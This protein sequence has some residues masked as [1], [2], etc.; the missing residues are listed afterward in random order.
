MGGLRKPPF[1]DHK[2]V[3]RLVGRY[4]HRVA[5]S[6]NRWSTL[7]NDRVSFMEGLSR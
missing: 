3:V 6:N 2:Q 1:G 4:T 5:I 7:K